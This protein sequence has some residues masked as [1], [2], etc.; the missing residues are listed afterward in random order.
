M[1]AGKAHGAIRI[2]QMVHFAHTA[3]VIPLRRDAAVKALALIGRLCIV[4]VAAGAGRILARQQ[5]QA[6]RHTYRRRRDAMVE[7]HTLPGQRVQMGRLNGGIAK[8]RDGIIPLLICKKNQNMLHIRKA[9]PFCQ[10]LLFVFKTFLFCF[11]SFIKLYIFSK[12]MSNDR[13]TKYIFCFYT[14]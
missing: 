5:R 7:N 8:G 9:P 3:A 13:I 2:P 6:G 14:F 11:V 12:G 10:V 4:V 1:A